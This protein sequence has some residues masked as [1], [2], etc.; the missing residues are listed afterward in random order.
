MRVA[1][2]AARC[3]P[4][5]SAC[6]TRA[7]W[8]PAPAVLGERQAD[9]AQQIELLERRQDVRI[10]R[11]LDGRSDARSRKNRYPRA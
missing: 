7:H 6:S 2:A 8:T 10:A 3:G 1:C 11:V 5:R 9:I 4:H